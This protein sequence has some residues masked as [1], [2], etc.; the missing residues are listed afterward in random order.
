MSLSESGLKSVSR[1]PAPIAVAID[2]DF[3][4]GQDTFAELRYVSAEL[5]D[6]VGDEFGNPDMRDCYGEKHQHDDCNVHIAH[7]LGRALVL[8][9]HVLDDVV[10]AFEFCPFYLDVEEEAF[11]TVEA[12]FLVD[13]G[14]R[15]EITLHIV[16]RFELVGVSEEL[17]RLVGI[18]GASHGVGVRGVV[19]HDCGEVDVVGC[20]R[21][22]AEVLGVQLDK[23][24]VVSIVFAVDVL[25]LHLFERG[26]DVG[27][28]RF[29]V[30]GV[31]VAALNFA[32]DA[33]L[34]RA[35]LVDFCGGE[36]E[37]V[38]IA[39]G[40]FFEH[41]DFVAEF[42]ICGHRQVEEL[43]EIFVEFLAFEFKIPQ[44]QVLVGLEEHIVVGIIQ[45]ERLLV[46]FEAEIRELDV[47]Y[48]FGV[49]VVVAVFEQ[50]YAKRD[51]HHGEGNY[52][53]Q[54]NKVQLG[55]YA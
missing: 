54:Q 53:T 4:V 21:D 45:Q 1:F 51:S 25:H 13:V 10:D 27:R 41:I 2:D 47:D 8:F 19:A 12:D 30:D 24:V 14:E 16:D 42:E 46:L 55:F 52:R 44:I 37:E 29:L 17:G 15:V 43:V 49:L 6:G 11:L 50:Q 38:A 28:Q 9:F 39:C 33:C 5:V 26:E 7:T 40:V 22:V 48:L 35:A 36:F 23:I 32:D 34:E 31:G 20:A 3:L 18:D